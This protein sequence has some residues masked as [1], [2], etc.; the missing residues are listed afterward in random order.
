MGIY[1]VAYIYIHSWKAPRIKVLLSLNKENIWASMN[2]SFVQGIYPLPLFSLNYYNNLKFELDITIP[3]Y[4]WENEGSERTHQSESDGTMSCPFPL[5][6][7]VPDSNHLCTGRGCSVL[8]AYWDLGWLKNV[9]PCGWLSDERL[10]F[11][12]KKIVLHCLPLWKYVETL[13]MEFLRLSPTSS[14]DCSGEL[15]L[16]MDCKRMFGLQ[17]LRDNTYFYPRD[18]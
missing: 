1:H 11:S 2:V 4:R 7:S 13:G 12:R 10:R 8:E 16:I 6:R 9:Q 17:S 14:L 3:F 15:Y 5:F 18:M